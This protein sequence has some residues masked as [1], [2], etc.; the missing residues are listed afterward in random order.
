M[1]DNVQVMTEIREFRVAVDVADVDELKQRLAR[2]RWTDQVPGAGD[3]YGDDVAKVRELA[4]YWAEEFDWRAVEAR[5]NSFPQFVTEVDGANIHFLTCAA[6][7][8]T[9]CRCC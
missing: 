2:T 9:R 8:R 7:T 1:A 6:R 3:L 4:R 5:L